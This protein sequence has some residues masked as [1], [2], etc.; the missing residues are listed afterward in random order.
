MGVSLK[1]DPELAADAR[2][3]YTAIAPGHHLNKRHWNTA[4]SMARYPMRN[5]WG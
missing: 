3:R 4:A 1:C 5:C 2:A